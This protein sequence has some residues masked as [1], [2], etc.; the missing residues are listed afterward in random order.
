[1]I[2]ALLMNVIIRIHPIPVSLHFTWYDACKQRSSVK[3]DLNKSVLKVLI[4][5]LLIKILSF[6]SEVNQF[7]PR[8]FLTQQVMQLSELMKLYSNISL[9]ALHFGLAMPNEHSVCF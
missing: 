4:I 3:Q 1:M 2:H 8:M 9:F 5:S 6:V 7:V